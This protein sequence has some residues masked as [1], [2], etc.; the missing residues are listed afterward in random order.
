MPELTQLFS[1]VGVGGRSIASKTDDAG[2]SGELAG[3]HNM[4]AS[5]LRV[6]KELFPPRIFGTEFVTPGGVKVQGLGFTNPCLDYHTAVNR[7]RRRL[8]AVAP[9]PFERGWRVIREELKPLADA[10]V[11]EETNN[12]AII[13][14]AVAEKWSAMLQAAELAL[15]SGFKASAYPKMEAV[16][17]RMVL[18]YRAKPFPSANQFATW[19]REEERARF[20]ESTQRTLR[21]GQREMYQQIAGVLQEV[22]TLWQNPDGHVLDA[23]KDRLLKQVQIAR[24]YHLG[25]GDLGLLMD[26]VE[27]QLN[28]IN[29]NRLR[30]NAALKATVATNLGM[31]AS[32]A[33]TVSSQ[34]E[35]SIL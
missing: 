5:D 9:M 28:G 16:Q 27:S 30:T 35:R 20:E 4:D 7:A 22:A 17:S 29:M 18:L 11:V 10:A 21:D 25:D 32:A 8:E 31:L 33:G 23:T 13:R 14:A 15:N 2:M 1:L 19:I 34:W 26:S 24:A 3:S 6:L 12:I